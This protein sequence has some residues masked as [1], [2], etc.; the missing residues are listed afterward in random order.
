MVFYTVDD[1]SNGYTVEIQIKTEPLLY[2]YDAIKHKKNLRSN[3][4][5]ESKLLRPTKTK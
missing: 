3:H 5:G 2:E 1:S 4:N